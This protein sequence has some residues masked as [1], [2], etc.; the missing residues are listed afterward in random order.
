ML[1]NDFEQDYTLDSLFGAN[2]RNKVCSALRGLG[3]ESFSVVN[4]NKEEI[5]RQGDL[6]ELDSV[7]IEL[8]VELEPVGHLVV[9]RSKEILA[10]GAAEFIVEILQ[11][12]W[13]YQMASSLHLQVSQ[14]DFEE[15]KQK[16]REL[17]E[18]ELR[19]KELSEN[20]EMR[21]NDQVKLIEESQRQLYEAEKFASVGH[22][23]AGMAHEI[24]TPVGFI[25]SNLSAA[26][27][28]LDE[29][30]E[31]VLSKNY[32]N[33]KQKDAEDL[34]FVLQDFFDLLNESKNG[35]KRI[36]SIVS[37][38][39]AFSNVEQAEEQKLDLNETIQL[40][41]RIFKTSIGG[42]IELVTDLHPVEK[43]IGKPAHINQ[44]LLNLLQNASQAF[45]VTERSAAEPRIKISSKMKEKQLEV[46]ISDN[47]CGMSEE[48][49]RQIFTPFYTTRDVGG[50]TGLGL[51]VCKDIVTAHNGSI[52]V[53]S[54][55]GMGTLVTLRFPCNCL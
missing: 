2:S 55:P 8:V 26:F 42:S 40:V 37:D 33:V 9:D 36:A 16:N 12:N 47:G 46:S 32:D 18:S 39:K 3:F 53:K 20:L 28:Y 5:L 41:S 1:A 10:K 44:L 27:D 52:E 24:N 4:L 45:S 21:V 6:T 30:K 54:K 17:A 48:V 11:I 35:A 23:A 51:T 22:L 19:Y 7:Q 14:S 34:E 29:I 49:I 13:R 15:L 43:I 38:L 50:G 31:K 25:Q